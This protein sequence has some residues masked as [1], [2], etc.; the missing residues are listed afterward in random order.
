MPGSTVLHAIV[1]EEPSPGGYGGGMIEA[2]RLAGC[3][4]GLHRLPGRPGQ[5]DRNAVL[6]G[7][8]ALARLPDRASVI[9]DGEVLA[10]LAAAIALDARRLRLTVLLDGTEAET[11]DPLQAPA[12]APDLDTVRRR[13]E[14]GTLAL[15]RHIVV[16]RDSVASALRAAGIE[17]GRIAVAPADAGGAERLLSL[18]SPTE[19][20]TTDARRNG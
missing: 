8:V 5:V 9:V 7:D 17:A 11:A 2:L 10:N 6:A 13:L 20:L 4:L 19:G 16:P 15:V 18:I 1:P 3:P 12:S 14:L